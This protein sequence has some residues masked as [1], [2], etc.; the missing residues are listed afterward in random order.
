MAR[1]KDPFDM[2]YSITKEQRHLL[3]Y[4]EC[5]DGILLLRFGEVFR[6]SKDVLRLHILEVK[7]VLLLKKM[8]LVL[9]EIK[10]DDP[11]AILD[12]SD[13]NLPV[14]IELGGTFRRRPDARGKWIKK[15]EE[16]LLHFFF[17]RMPCEKTVDRRL[18]ERRRE[19]EKEQIKKLCI[20]EV[21]ALTNR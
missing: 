14:L 19:K 16:R 20:T 8:G 4:D 13:A 5:K 7:T 9:N 2:K 3:W 21:P 15:M 6:V 17:V 1:K 11:F 18:E 12:V 10:T